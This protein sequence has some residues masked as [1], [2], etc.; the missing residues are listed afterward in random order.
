AVAESLAPRLSRDPG[1]VRKAYDLISHCESAGLIGSL[2]GMAERQDKT[3]IL[4]QIDLPA[5]V[6]AGEEDQITNFEESKA[7]ADNLPGGEFSGLQGVGHMP[8][9]E[10][11]EALGVALRRLIEQVNHS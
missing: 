8:M 1:V 6:V 2:Q 4:G 9:L 3:G 11:P 5:L 7:M 10:D